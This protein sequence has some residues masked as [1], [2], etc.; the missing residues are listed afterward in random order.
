MKHLI[1]KLFLSVLLQ[2][3]YVFGYIQIALMYKFYVWQINEW[4]LW[5]IFV[6]LYVL[7]QIIVYKIYKNK[8]LKKETH[9]DIYMWVNGAFIV[10]ETWLLL[11]SI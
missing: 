11:I 7:V 1:K 3:I 5:L 8:P 9:K 10:L 2:C 6:I 4:I